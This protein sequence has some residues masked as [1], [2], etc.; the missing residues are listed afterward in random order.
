MSLDTA[1]AVRWLNDTAALMRE[2]REELVDLDRA[3]GDGDHGENMDRGF[4]ALRKRLEE[5]EPD[6]IASALKLTAKTLMSTVGGA[7]GPL[8]GTAFL[9]AAKVVNAP[10]LEAADVNALVEAM[11]DGV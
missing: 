10:A 11:L 9:R 2:N 1:W 3:I 8:Y 6:S 5:N 7:A 4:T